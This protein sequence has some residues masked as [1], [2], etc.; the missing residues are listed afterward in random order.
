[1][2]ATPPPTDPAPAPP[3]TPS[4]GTGA[5]G[6]RPNEAVRVAYRRRYETDYIFT[7]AG[8]NCFLTLITC[9]IFGFYLLYKLMERMREHNR[10]RLQLLDGATTFA[11]ERAVEQGLDGELRPAFE[12]IAGHLEPLRR[13]TRDFRDP[14]A[15]LG[16]ALAATV[17]A[18]AGFVVYFICFYLL[19]DDLH[20]HDTNEGAVEAELAAIY[21]RLGH[22]V[23]TPDPQRVRGKHNYAGRIVA[24]IATCGIYGLWWLYDMQVGPNEHFA[25]NWQWEDGLANAVQAMEPATT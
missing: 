9:G 10:R 1:M 19:D 21:T 16:I 5:L 6:L 8:L 24:T 13:M 4:W 22:P 18:N 14:G 3:P 23:P 12:R 2:T 20:Q 11:W 15:W 7:G 25:I 17:F